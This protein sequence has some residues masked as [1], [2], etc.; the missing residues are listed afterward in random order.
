M[1]STSVLTD[2]TERNKAEAKLREAEE[3]WR[4]TFDSMA[5][6]VSIHDT[7]GTIV[8]ANRALGELL[9]IPGA[10]LRGM[11]YLAASRDTDQ[12][13]SEGPIIASVKSKKEERREY[14]DTHLE[15]WL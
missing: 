9:A 8:K 2:V 15:R 14:Y 11:S 7:S 4:I 12:P 10:E 1:G 5:D 13:D 6:Y 3:E